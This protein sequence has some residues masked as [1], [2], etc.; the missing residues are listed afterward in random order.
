VRPTYSS[1]TWL[2]D[3]QENTA[4]VFVHG[5]LS[6]PV[7][8]WYNKE[9]DAYW[10][11]IVKADVT[12]GGA[13]VFLGGY[14]TGYTSGSYGIRDCAQ[15]L[16]TGLSLP[17]GGYPPVLEHE[18]I[19]FVCHS[20]GGIVTRYVLEAWRQ[21]FQS[22]AILLVLVASPSLGSKYAVWLD[23]VI[24]LFENRQGSQLAWRSEIIEDLDRRFKDLKDQPLI[25]RLR[26]CEF[27][28]Q[29]FPLPLLP[30]LV[31][32]LS[33]ARY[34][35]DF[36]TVPESTHMSIVK[37][38]HAQAFSHQLLQRYFIEF[39]RK[40]R[41]FG[42]V[43][44]RPAE[45]GLPAPA[46]AFECGRLSWSVRINANGDGHN[47]IAFER[48]FA[49]R[50]GE[51]TKY[52]L[53]KA[54]IDAGY[55]SRFVVD[56]AK[57]SPGIKLLQDEQRRRITDVE[58]AA[59]FDQ[60]PSRELPQN[61]L[62]QM[63]HFHAYALD[64]YGRNDAFDYVEKS[65]AFE[66]FDEFLFEVGFPETLSLLEAPFVMAFQSFPGRAQPV[67]DAEL[68]R[69]AAAGFH[70][71]PMARTA[72]LRIS[73][74]PCHSAY[75]ISW[76]LGDRIIAA[77]TPTDLQLA[78]AEARR[79]KLLD[80]RDLIGSP[81]TTADNPCRVAVLTEL[82]RFGAFTGKLLER[83][84]DAPEVAAVLQALESDLEINIMVF[85]SRE[86]VLKFVA[87]TGIGDLWN[88][89]LNLGEG[90]AGRAADWLQAQY[91]D[92]ER[93]RHTVVAD[94]YVELAPRK[95]HSWLLSIPLWIAADGPAAVGVLNLG[96]FN[97]RFAII[98][99]ALNRRDLIDELVSQAN[100][101][102]L[103]AI[104]KA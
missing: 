54:S 58:A 72:Y 19:V 55:M 53:A 69:Q 96:T 97:D 88:A 49:V 46:Q 38:P 82:A 84:L 25:P 24:E 51:G 21:A 64:R 70:F 81:A 32:E 57:T 20:L 94:S 13:G 102:L 23:A 12:F 39:D 16:F 87:G 17:F 62:L 9:A 77:M 101:T 2:G 6:D 40:Y 99:R 67:L 15:E 43:T 98:L 48:I 104:L 30:P 56:T 83:V 74:P 61:L 36:Q 76:R 10:P 73:K 60:D 8:C 86:K 34:F 52:Q 47:E 4:I 75:R 91:Y 90:I 28:E 50:S 78:Q 18:R 63:L 79:L 35:G 31:S 26:G 5:V 45:T 3:H 22:Q 103:P 41:A 85:E 71:S 65:I 89:K 42:R 100:G 93:A 95:R 14:S 29:K 68:T 33:A 59:L 37:P 7:A 66:R 80:I 44:K 27:I 92:D 11:S 1:N